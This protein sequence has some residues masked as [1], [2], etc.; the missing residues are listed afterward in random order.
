M[1]D[2]E[3]TIARALPEDAARRLADLVEVPDEASF[4]QFRAELEMAIGLVHQ[5]TALPRSRWKPITAKSDISPAIA[6]VAKAARA[7]DQAL[8]ALLV[9]LGRF[10]E[11][12]SIAGSLL[13][14]ALDGAAGEV[15]DSGV[16]P[17]LTAYREW[18]TTLIGAAEA[19]DSR[20]AEL[21]PSEVG[22]PTGS[23]NPFFDYF[24]KRLYEISSKTG[25]QSWTY[26][27]KADNSASGTLIQAL[28]LLQDHL[29]KSDFVPNG[30]LGNVLEP[31][32]KRYRPDA[33]AKLN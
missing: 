2:G 28:D 23:G 31:L 16:R 21:W 22:R 10:D 27:K 1:T 6:S 24:V 5:L 32:V 18:L 8:G 13:E 12:A 20:A 3:D 17:R 14:Q 29:P 15:S 9:E 25:K 11:G 26:W 19:A 33:S 30:R 7:L 4:V